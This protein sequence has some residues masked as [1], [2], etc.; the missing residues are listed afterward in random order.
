M[1]KLKVLLAVCLLIFAAANSPAEDEAVPQVGEAEAPK[2]EETSEVAKTE[3]KTSTKKD[4]DIPKTVDAETAAKNA[5]ENKKLTILNQDEPDGTLPAVN[6]DT[7][8]AEAKPKFKKSATQDRFRKSRLTKDDSEGRADRRKV[9]LSTGEDKVVDL[10]FDIESGVNGIIVG[11]PKVALTTLVRVEDKQRQIVF[12][13]LAAGETTVTVRDTQGKIK[14]IFDVTVTPNNLLRRAGEIRDLLKDVEGIEVKV[15]GQNVVIDGEILVPQD[16]ARTISVITNKPYADF[17]L[18]LMS[19][20]PLALHTLSKKIQEDVLSFAPNIKT[21]VV[22]GMV[23]LEGTVDS[24]DQ[25]RRAETLAQLYLPEAKPGNPIASKDPTANVIM[26]RKMV[27]NFIV[28]NP[29]PPKKQEKLVRMTVHVVELNKDYNR[30][31]GFNWRPLFTT[32]PQISVGQ[33]ADGSTGAAATTFTGTLSGLFPKL[34]TAQD[35][36][37]AR[38]I[39]QGTVLVRSGLK[40]VMDDGSNFLVPTTSAQGVTTQQAVPV[41]FRIETTPQI[42]GQSEDIQVALAV[43][44]QVVTGVSTG[45]A[46]ITS[47]KGIN[48]TLYVKSAE[49][50]AIGGF[51]TQDVSTGFNR[52]GQGQGTSDQATTSPLFNLKR[53]KAYAK[54]RT[55]FVV[56]VTPQIIENASDGS[57]DLK[58]NFRIK[59]K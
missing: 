56:F 27:Q 57:D 37:F 20:S 31:F 44:N 52:D 18:P 14:V 47:E 6:S 22:N 1:T 41:R 51:D 23:F 2:V 11:N 7:V 26:G 35:A 28:V 39:K 46:P 38:I 19:L 34:Q 24:I 17:V 8:P 21:R 32:D 36:G 59:V 3:T 25:A 49:S 54:K 30:S 53:S 13:P 40:A 42:L 58:K 48:T 45:G 16:Y 15:V 50:A 43:T 9:L 33:Q 10:D 29:P 55:Q 5:A 4:K 12:K